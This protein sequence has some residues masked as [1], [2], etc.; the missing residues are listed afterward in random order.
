MGRKESAHRANVRMVLFVVIM[1]SCVGKRVS[2]KLRKNCEKLHD[3]EEKSEE[4]IAAA[5]DGQG[6]EGESLP[7]K[8]EFFSVADVDAGLKGGWIYPATHK[9]IDRINV[10]ETLI[11]IMVEPA[12][13]CRY[14]SIQ[15]SFEIHVSKSYAQV[16]VL[17]GKWGRKGEDRE[18]WVKI[19][20]FREKLTPK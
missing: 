20:P 14:G 3:D 6:E 8:D 2:A 16:C 1:E 10:I 7:S 5:E 11:L 15:S 9:I 13:K 12:Y 17:L 18:G 19:P 4:L